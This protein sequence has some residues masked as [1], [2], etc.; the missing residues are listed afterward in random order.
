MEFTRVSKYMVQNNNLS[1]LEQI[2]KIDFVHFWGKG[3]Q[4]NL[5]QILS[6]NRKHLSKVQKNLHISDFNVNHTL[7]RS[8]NFSL[9]L[10]QK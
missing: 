2:S 3:E 7:R 8:L 10:E 6:N 5:L 4:E 1:T 9:H